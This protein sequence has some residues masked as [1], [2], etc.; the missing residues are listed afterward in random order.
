MVL[1]FFTTR[2]PPDL[3]P[4]LVDRLAAAARRLRPDLRPHVRFLAV[5]LD[6]AHDRPGVLRAFGRMPALL[7]APDEGAA[8]R[9]WEGFGV[10]TW[11][12]DDG[13]LGH[14]LDTLVID[15]DGALAASFAGAEG[16]GGDDL[17]A[18][19]VSAVDP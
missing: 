2:C 7:A 1:T 5:T 11:P 6:P 4:S 10:V 3:C 19:V 15:D 9:W 17:V 12:R 8:E 16:W 18:A 13:T 14:T